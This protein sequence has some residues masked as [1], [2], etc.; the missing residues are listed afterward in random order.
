MNTS[1][2]NNKRLAKN[3]ILLYIRTIFTML[4]SL[5]TSRIVLATLG[6]E[7]Y[8]I[9]NV[10]G[11]IV[12]MF[13]V[14]SGSLSSAISRFITFELGHGN[15]EK[16][17]KIFSTSLNIQFAISFLVLILGETIGYWFLNYKMNIPIERLYA[18]N[19]VLHCSLISFVIN[20]IS[21]PYNAA[22]IAHERMSAFAYVSILEAVLKLAVVYVLFISL[23]DKLIIY[24]VLLVMVSLIVRVVYGIYCNRHF[25]EVHY[26]FVYD[27]SLVKEMTEFAG[28]NFFTNTAYVLNTQ[29][30]NILINLF[31]GVGVN[32]A[33]GIAVQVE[34]TMM[35]FVNDFTTAINPQ[36]TKS[37]ASGDMEE[38]NRLVMSG[39]KISYFLVFL[40][41][42][43]VLMETNYILNLWLEEVP[44]HT[45]E[46]IR[47]ATIATII[48]R[49]GN[50][51]YT[52]CMATGNIRRYVLW[53]TSIGCLSFPLTYIVYT[54]GASV[55]STYVVFIIVYSVVDMVRLWIMKDLLNFSIRLFFKE[56]IMKILIVSLMSCIIPLF[57]MYF[58]DSS[59]IRFITV[60][61]ICILST[62]FSIYI[63]G[64]K[65]LERETI[66]E[67]VISKF[68]RKL[69]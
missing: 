44:E 52:A 55:E 35:R 10:V 3:T 58:M 25:K 17:K 8:G 48:D 34:S 30:V 6:V 26:Q 12:A 41:S 33:R 20:L 45:V 62:L 51:G 53:I 31:F 32:A 37:Y 29:G 46:F 24:S 18:A 69:K 63:W 1:I 16:L 5:Y 65:K 49:L 40:I 60:S 42:L 15:P 7:D 50:T 21:I 43:P 22:I 61:A 28:W 57:M 23:W 56:V 19:W 38:M 67:K 9:Y 11:G 36:I 2:N 13:S 54:L 47:L 39:A 4:I 68:R 14:I 66:S 64:L 59:F 27:K